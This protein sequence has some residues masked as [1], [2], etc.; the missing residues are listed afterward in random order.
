[1]RWQFVFRGHD[2]GHKPL[3]TSPQTHDQRLMHASDEAEM[4]AFSADNAC[5]TST[6]SIDA[7][8]PDSGAVSCPPTSIETR[9]L[10]LLMRSVVLAGHG[11]DN[12]SLGAEEI[13]C[14]FA[15]GPLGEVGEYG[16][17]RIAQ[18]A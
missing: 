11:P 14:P 2:T 3:L 10:L 7:S 16:D 4:P 18:A 1:M 17:R 8:H 12:A 9:L 15:I 6:C 13:V 5:A